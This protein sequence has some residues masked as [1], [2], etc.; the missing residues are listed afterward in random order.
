MHDTSTGRATDPAARAHWLD[1]LLAPLTWVERAQGRWRLALVLLYALI[2]GAIGLVAGREV[3]LWSLPDAPEPVDPDRYGH[4]DLADEDNAMVFYRQ[5]V[6]L[7]QR[8]E[9][10]RRGLPG[11]GGYQGDWALAAPEVRAWAEAN[12]PALDL[13]LRGTTLPDALVD[14]PGRRRDVDA[15]VLGQQLLSL[16]HLGTLAATRLQ[17]A[18]TLKG[19]W[20]YHRGVIRSALHATR[21]VGAAAATNASI[22]LNRTAPLVRAWADHPAMTSNLLRGALADL[23]ACRPLVPDPL[24]AIRVDYLGLRDLLLDPTRWERW[25]FPRGDLR[26]WYNHVAAVEWAREF[27][28]N[29]PKRSLRVLRLVYTGVL[30]NAARPPGERPPLADRR[31]PIYA[32]DAATPAPLARIRPDA[33]VRWVDASGCRGQIPDYGRTLGALQGIA[34]LLDGHRLHFARRAFELDHANRAPATYADLWPAYLDAL[35]PGIAATDPV[36]PR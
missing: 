11:W 9:T 18:G 8:P 30:A 5:A 1:V 20:R 3:V 14:Q 2:L 10:P 25:Q 4:V 31:Y 6:D 16:G 26:E 13:W 15:V 32:V 33:L 34:N 21:H 36:D 28:Q 23:A 22:S 27:A 12:G 7:L 19:A 17:E 29:E 35:P 24:A